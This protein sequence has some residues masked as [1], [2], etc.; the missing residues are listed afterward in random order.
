MLNSNEIEQSYERIRPYI[1]KTPII[2]LETG[3]FGSQAS[4]NLKLECLQ[5]TGSFKSRG[6]FNR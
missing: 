6:A 5:H 2:D 3:A 4:I 1:R